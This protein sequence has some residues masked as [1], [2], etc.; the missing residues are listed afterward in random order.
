MITSG[1]GERAVLNMAHLGPGNTPWILAGSSTPVGFAD[2]D[3]SN[4]QV[5]QNSVN[6]G[7]GFLRAIFGEDYA[8]P[9]ETYTI[10]LQAFDG[11]RLVGAV[12][13]VVEIF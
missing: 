13:T 1:D 2:E 6:L 10:E 5:S 11:L 3:G 7:F 4:P 12:S 8:D 9:G